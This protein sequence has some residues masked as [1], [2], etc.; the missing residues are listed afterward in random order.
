MPV[1]DDV[2][3]VFLDLGIGAQAEP[4]RRG[5]DVRIRDG[6]AVEAQGYEAGLGRDRDRGRSRTPREAPR[7]AVRAA[8]EAQHRSTPAL[9]DGLRAGADRDAERPELAVAGQRHPRVGI[10]R[11][12][13][14]ELGAVV[15]DVDG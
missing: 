4:Q 3:A 2:Q 14:H 11:P 1:N 12:G 10:H 5:F 8:R 15:V 6:L 9:D 13:L 7:N